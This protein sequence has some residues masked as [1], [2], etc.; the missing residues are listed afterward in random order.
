MAASVAA[1]LEASVSSN[2]ADIPVVPVSVKRGRGRPPSSSKSQTVVDAIPAVPRQLRVV[3]ARQAARAQEDQPEPKLTTPNAHG[4]DVIQ[5]GAAI[6]NGHS[7]SPMK[8]GRG[9]PPSAGGAVASRG[10]KRGRPARAA[11]VLKEPTVQPAI[12]N[13]SAAMVEFAT[14]DSDTAVDSGEEIVAR[15]N[16][17]SVERGRRGRKPGRKNQSPIAAAPPGTPGRRGRKP[18]ST[19]AAIEAAAAVADE[20]PS[21][22]DETDLTAGSTADIGKRSSRK[23]AAAASPDRR[24]NFNN[25]CI[26]YVAFLVPSESASAVTKLY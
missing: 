3:P 20:I 21:G 15:P 24:Q 13:A 19:L 16:A 10:G 17:S 1:A 12:I 25:F 14:T 18:K 7:T 9:R 6:V 5:Q 2:Q 26:S 11:A 8:R 4:V 23:T 22:T